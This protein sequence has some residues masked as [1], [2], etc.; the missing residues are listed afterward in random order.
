MLC[1]AMYLSMYAITHAVS[2]DVCYYVLYI[3][4]LHA[5]Y[6]MHCILCYHIRWCAVFMVT[7]C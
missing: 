2:N 6:V 1:Y 3:V 4:P 7:T 5:I